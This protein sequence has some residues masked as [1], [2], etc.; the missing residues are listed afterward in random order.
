MS[1]L[2]DVCGWDR[3]KKKKGRWKEKGRG[4]KQKKNRENILTLFFSFFS[5]RCELALV[6]LQAGTTSCAHAISK[7]LV[8]QAY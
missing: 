4:R 3:E 8:A 7:G 6:V 1:I 5:S 2:V